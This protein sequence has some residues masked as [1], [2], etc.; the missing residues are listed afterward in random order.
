MTQMPACHLTD[1]F[2]PGATAAP[3]PW[4]RTL[5]SMTFALMLVSLW[6]LTHRYNGFARDGEL[7]AVQAMARIHPSLATDLY[8]QNV[9]QDRFTVFSPIY[10]A[11]IALIGL[12]PAELLLFSLCTV[13]FLT[14]AGMLARELFSV[15]AA[16]LSTALL[17]VTTGYYGAYMIFSYS[18]NY[19][20]ARSM[21]EALVVTALACHFRGWRTATWLIAVA[22]MC[23]HPL[24]VLPG[25]LLLLCLGL[26]TRLA[27][28]GA[29][30]GVLATL[31]FA[32]TATFTHGTMPFMTLMD[33]A[34]LEVVRERSQ[35]L[36]L[37]Y[38]TVNDWG[39]AA[40]PVVCLT[41]T[42]LAVP[43]ERVRKLCIAALLVGAAGLAVA[44]IAGTVGPVAILLQGQAWR[45][46]W[47]TGFVSVLLVVPTALHVWR[48]ERCGPLCATL[49]VLAWTFQGIDS[50]ACADAALALWLVRPYI[51]ARTGQHLRWA[52]AALVAIVV[53]WTVANCWTFAFSAI[54]ESGREPIIVGRLRE[55]F[56]LGVSAVLLA[57]FV[58][59][60]ARRIRS[61]PMVALVAAALVATS[62][63]ILPGSVKQ[64]SA[65]GSPAEIAEFADW[66]AAIPPTSNVL[67]VPTTKSA[68]FVWFTLG[69]PSYL[70]VDQSAGVIFSP[71]TARE[72][73]RR[74]EILAPLGDPDWR[75]LSAITKDRQRRE[76]GLPSKP[77]PPPLKL[78][79]G[80]LTSV[81]SDPALGF[82]VAEPNVGFNP[83][84]H[85]HPGG[86]NRWNLYDCRRVRPTTPVAGPPAA[87]S[88]A[89]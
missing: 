11:V 27:V 48:A 34:W 49:L 51:T 69:R 78:T 64:M 61:M 6:A 83:V 41:F 32:L 73:R 19:L 65:V 38:W 70:S 12:Q 3:T 20:S 47:V 36:F 53:L 76:A 45:W 58:W 57:G 43:D 10:A 66:R 18:E 46:M 84:T 50:L 33:P 62:V 59:Y 8:L 26:P 4:Q 42:A 54:P 39:L 86:W 14:A 23:I 71:A 30:A 15:E 31:A 1:R 79:A 77:A 40:R 80:M 52:G 21:G 56:G 75:I 24:M 28:S 17:I 16:W 63:T 13:V 87:G 9:S 89:A 37:K 74:S 25:V 72:V 82:V 55:M 60:G 2:G 68:A 35:F 29:V 85:V 88:P 67:M 5:V 22:G 44:L 7:Y 81:C